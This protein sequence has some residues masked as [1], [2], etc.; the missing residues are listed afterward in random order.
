MLYIATY[1]CNPLANTSI[2]LHKQYMQMCS[3]IPHVAFGI[4]NW[5]RQLQYNA[6]KYFWYV[7]SQRTEVHKVINDGFAICT[8]TSLF[9]ANF[10]SLGLFHSLQAFHEVHCNC[11]QGP[12]WMFY[13]VQF[14]SSSQMFHEHCFVSYEQHC[15]SKNLW[16][17]SHSLHTAFACKACVAASNSWRLQST[18]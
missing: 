18:V 4:M 7:V 12:E 15:H 9:F 17:Y 3:D 1:I 11:Y 10:L 16:Y 2:W 14:V 6:K 13:R 5:N 8:L